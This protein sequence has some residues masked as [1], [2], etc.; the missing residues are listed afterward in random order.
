M[1]QV[2]ERNDLSIDA[3]KIWYD[4]Q[5][6]YIEDIIGAGY[7]TV[8]AVGR[9]TIEREI[10][11]TE[12]PTD[13]EIYKYS[14]YPEREITVEFLLQKSNMLQFREA[15]SK[16]MQLLNTPQQKFIFNGEADYYFTGTAVVSNTI[17]ETSNG[18]IGAYTIHC[19]DPFKYSVSEYELTATVID[20]ANAQFSFTY[21][22]TYKS[23][24]E[25]SIEF[26]DELD[27]EG[28][29]TDASE[30]GFVGIEAHD[31][32][33]LQF[34]D[35]EEKDY[36][37]IQYPDTVPLNKKFTTQDAV[38]SWDLNSAATLG[39]NYTQAGTASCNTTKKYVY[40]SSYGSGSKYHGPAISHIL[41]DVS[42]ALN[43]VFEWK[44]V[45]TATKK[46]FGAAQVLLYNNNGGTRKLIAGVNLLKTT[47][48]AKTA[49]H[50][51]AG[52]TSN[53]VTK[54]GIKCSKI[55]KSSITKRGNAV[56]FNIAGFSKKL[57]LTDEQAALQVNEVVLYFAKNGSKTAMGTN[58]VYNCKLTRSAY[59]DPDADIPNLFTPG[60]LLTIDTATAGVWMDFGD[61]DGEIPAQNVG[62]L[63][64][65]WETMCI[66]PGTNIF[67]I[68]YSDW[69][70]T[71][72][73]AKMK[74][75]KRYL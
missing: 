41:T 50:M 20:P 45:F 8:K 43:F 7:H 30:N 47:K 51:Y 56:T 64:N 70:T 67:H 25:F 55:G 31:G 62:A 61:G 68:E 59:S 5:Y 21:D 37:E 19:Y 52:S 49:I 54:K 1:A 71:A 28:N 27:A 17:Q 29:N 9:E 65:D 18:M 4:G 44:H 3:V 12:T 58:G 26:P 36:G 40:A 48:N 24:P 15:M 35:A 69:I 66:V 10:V 14:S 2:K 57:T 73:V 11:K 75:R 6:R 23:F 39:T 13:G 34:G 38:N 60:T 22:G 16:L 63:G 32:S 33:V 42:D 53:K 72:P 74:Y 46:Q